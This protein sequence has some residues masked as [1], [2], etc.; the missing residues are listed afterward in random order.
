MADYCKKIV[1]AM[2]EIDLSAQNY[3]KMTSAVQIIAQQTNLL[4]LNASVEAARAGTAG[5]GFAVVANEVRS[6]ALSSQNTVSTSEENRRDIIDAISH[7]NQIIGDINSIA[8]KLTEMSKGMTTKVNA[9]SESG[10]SIGKSMEQVAT[11]SDEVNSLL[12]QTNEKL[13]QL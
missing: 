3:S 6:L 13:K 4:S 1:T 11:L 8:T 10:Q 9:T 7:V 5:K 12:K 2:E